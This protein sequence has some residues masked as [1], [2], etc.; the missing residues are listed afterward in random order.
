MSM[1]G[2]DCDHA[3]AASTVGGFFA[4]RG[5]TP[6]AAQLVRL[7]E[8]LDQ[9]PHVLADDAADAVMQLTRTLIRRGGQV[10]ELKRRA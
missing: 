6:A 1:A 8:L 2:W 10:G 3:L 4:L 9:A 7:L 5:G